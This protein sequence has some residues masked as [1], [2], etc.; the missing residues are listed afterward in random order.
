MQQHA[1]ATKAMPS[2][3]MFKAADTIIP[4]C[5]ALLCCRRKLLVLG[6]VDFFDHADS[7]TNLT[8]AVQ[9]HLLI[10][11]DVRVARPCTVNHNQRLAIALR[12]KQVVDGSN[13]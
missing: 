7:V 3:Q 6:L 4:M 13:F 9:P 2:L 10:Y 11:D 8:S 5:G 12:D 1:T